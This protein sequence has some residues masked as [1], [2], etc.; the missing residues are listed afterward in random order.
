MA[1][2]AVG[3][4]VGLGVG[5]AVG[6]AG[7]G[8]VGESVG[9]SVVGAAVGN[10]VGTPPRKSRELAPLIALYAPQPLTGIGFEPDELKYS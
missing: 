9:D 2:G 6:V 7:V 1:D 8:E 5:F 4:S 10:G 3:A